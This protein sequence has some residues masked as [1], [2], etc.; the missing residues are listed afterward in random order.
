MHATCTDRTAPSRAHDMVMVII[1]CV[2]AL[3]LYCP[4]NIHH[5][6]KKG[7]FLNV[8]AFYTKRVHSLLVLHNIRKARELFMKRNITFALKWRRRLAYTECRA[9]ALL[10]MGWKKFC[11][12]SHPKIVTVMLWHRSI[13]SI[14]RNLYGRIQ[15]CSKVHL[16]VEHLCDMVVFAHFHRRS[17]S[18]ILMQSKSRLVGKLFATAEFT[19]QKSR[20]QHM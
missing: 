7:F 6:L 13:S 4:I 10:I 11:A 12:D 3:A 17:V 14:P 2:R 1:S 18:I 8:R 16:Q 5:S 20:R 9:N 15:L 19:Y